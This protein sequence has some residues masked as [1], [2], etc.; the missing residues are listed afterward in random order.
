MPLCACK[1][2]WPH[3]SR[4]AKPQVGCE[5]CDALECLILTFYLINETRSA[6]EWKPLR[7]PLP[8]PFLRYLGEMRLP[9]QQR[10]EPLP[11]IKG[12]LGDHFPVPDLEGEGE[13][14]L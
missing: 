12:M 4:V 13:I 11:S 3:R 9:S 8:L 2:P 5:G 1:G 7:P 6:R 10:A 14:P